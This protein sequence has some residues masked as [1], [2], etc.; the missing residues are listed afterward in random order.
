MGYECTIQE[1]RLSDAFII[2]EDLKEVAYAKLNTHEIPHE[3][4]IVNWSRRNDQYLDLVT[5]QHDLRILKWIL[6]GLAI[7]VTLCVI[8]CICGVVLGILGLCTCFLAAVNGC[9]QM[10]FRRG[11]ARGYESF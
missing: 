7:L 2:F 10:I 4:S 5:C 8:G 3:Q 11:E 6:I 9:Y 1:W